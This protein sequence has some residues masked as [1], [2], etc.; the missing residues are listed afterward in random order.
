MNAVAVDTDGHFLLSS[1]NTSE[2]TKINSDTGEIIWRLGGTHNQ[3]S[4]VNDPLNGPRNQHAIRPLGNNHYTLFDNGDGHN[5]QVSRA[6]EYEIDPAA[7]KAT[8]VWQYPAVPTTSLY[9]FYMGNAQRLPNGNTLINWAVG[10]LPKL[11]EVRPDGTLA[12]EM[13]WVNQYEAYRVW[14]CPWQGVALKPYLILEAYPDNVTLLF[15]QFGDSNVVTYRIFGGTSPQPTTLLATSGT[16]L[17]QLTNLTNG[18]RYYFRVAAVDKNGAQGA[19]SNEESVVVNI[20]K[21]GQNMLSNGD[22]AADTGS[23]TW[24]V[25]SP[26]VATWIITGGYSRVA[27]T[28]AGTGVSNIQL[29]QAG[30]PLIKGNKYVFEFDAWSSGTRYID[31]KVAQDAAPNTNYSGT[32]STAL[33]PTKTRFRYVF[34]MQDASDFNSRVV[35][36]L[37][38]SARVVYLDNISLF[39]P[40]PGDINMDGRVD[41][42]DLKVMTD[43][44]LK[45]QTNLPSDLNGDGK[46]DFRDF[47]ILG[48]NRSGGP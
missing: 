43:E 21:P 3:F 40:P 26:A 5:P 1:R 10:N 35:F 46:V 25:T 7:M 33:T 41:L 37:G 39:N 45:Q 11:T 9:S 4:Y 12:F 24:Q 28:N 30:I 29:R 31:A 32:G 17:K 44:W 34:T 36:N 8:V 18:Q 6:V 23:W 22:F 2:I 19:Y 14:R 47:G 38:T 20:I 15:N 48:D 42:L 27:I 16:T 13:N